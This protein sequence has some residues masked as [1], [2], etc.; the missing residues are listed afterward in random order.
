MWFWSTNSLFLKQMDSKA[1]KRMSLTQL[2]GNSQQMN[3]PL[4]LC[5]LFSIVLVYCYSKKNKHFKVC[6]VGKYWKQETLVKMKCVFRQSSWLLKGL[7]LI[8][9]VFSHHPKL[10]NHCNFMHQKGGNLKLITHKSSSYV[11]RWH[12]WWA[13]GGH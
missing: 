7:C 5:V 11:W 3:D 8:F 9:V 10:W 12:F 6:L 1:L 4:L 13:G 2:H